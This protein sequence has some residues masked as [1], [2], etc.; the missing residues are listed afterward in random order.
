MQDNA[1][2]RDIPRPDLGKKLPR[3]PGLRKPVPASQPVLPFTFRA[4]P[5]C[6][7]YTGQSFFAQDKANFTF[8]KSATQ[9]SA[10]CLF[11]S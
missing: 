3:H 4:F 10:V 6:V 2:H 1:S 11:D 8:S 9:F 7:V 5:N